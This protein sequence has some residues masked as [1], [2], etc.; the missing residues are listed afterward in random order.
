MDEATAIA[1]EVLAALPLAAILAKVVEKV[2]WDRTRVT[3]LGQTFAFM[4]KCVTHFHDVQ[5]RA[6]SCLNNM[7]LVLP[8]PAGT[9]LLRVSC[10]SCVCVCVVCVCRVC[11]VCLMC[12]C[13]RCACGGA[14]KQQ[15][16][17]LWELLVKL[18]VEAGQPLP[19]PLGTDANMETL[20]LVTASMWTL[21]RKST[22]HGFPLVPPP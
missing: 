10:V 8:L 6:L 9:T 2:Q 3:A 21:L 11:V 15:A 19:P 14:D 16:E 20:E 1:P 18:C 12:G 13:V 5:A 4:Q 7:L 22:Q 17:G